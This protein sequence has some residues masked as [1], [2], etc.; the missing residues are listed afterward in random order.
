[1]VELF[2]DNG[3]GGGSQG[4]CTGPS[5][6]FFVRR[7]EI[8]S[9]IAIGP[10]VPAGAAVS[11]V[12]LFWHDA[13]GSGGWRG[14]R[15]KICGITRK[16]DARAAERAGA[17]AIGV[18]VCSDSPR[19][20]SLERAAGIF[21]S[22]GPFVTTVAVT[23]TTSDAELARI[24]AIQ[25]HGVQLFHPFPRPCGYRGRIIR[26]V[27]SG[28]PLPGDGDEVAI[29]ESAGSGKIYD[30][31]FA[32]QVV[33]R[34]P[35]PVILCG[36]LTPENVGEAVRSVRPYAVDVC[37]GVERSPGIKDH[38]LVERFIGAAKACD[39]DRR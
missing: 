16:E 37:T 20:V 8:L 5:D 26:V 15:V 32:R 12:S 6:A 27:K 14:I 31:V 1:M 17:D 25:P 11:V 22:V 18:V 21:S 10:T 9:A 3:S 39:D 33:A 35:V 34:S 23:H 19:S 38:R 28:A 4:W 36:G 24:L 13:I 29:D 30:G 7:K 2:S